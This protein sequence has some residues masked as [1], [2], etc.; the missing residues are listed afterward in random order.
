MSG[1]TLKSAWDLTLTDE[2]DDLDSS[3]GLRRRFEEYEDALVGN[4]LDKMNSF[5]WASPETVRFG[6]A[7]FEFGYDE[8]VRWRAEHWSIPPGR[9][10][11]ETR[12]LMVSE[13]VGVI[14]TLFEYP[15]R[16]LLGMQSQVWR[17]FDSQVWLVVSAHVSEIATS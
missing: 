14:T 13:S 16:A 9:K 6:I 8:I 1:Q 10:L 3:S 12:I 5:F 7:D 15:E 2:R 4:D 17:R 11:M